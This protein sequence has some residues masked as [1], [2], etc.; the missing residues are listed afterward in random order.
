MKHEVR[1]THSSIDRSCGVIL[2]ALDDWPTVRLA[3]V[4]KSERSEERPDALARG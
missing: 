2:T 1:Q 4:S 3:K